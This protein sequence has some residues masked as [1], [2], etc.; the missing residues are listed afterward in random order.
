V[1]LYLRVMAEMMAKDGTISH[2]IIRRLKHTQK[3]QH[4]ISAHFLYRTVRDLQ[5][6]VKPILGHCG[7]QL[8]TVAS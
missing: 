8:F 7:V 5:Y 6:T 3:D 2:H 1:N 4:K